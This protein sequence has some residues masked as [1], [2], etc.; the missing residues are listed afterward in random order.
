MDTERASR[1]ASQTQAQARTLVELRRSLHATIFADTPDLAHID[2]LRAS[3][4]EAEAAALAARV[5]LEM[6]IAQILTPEQRAQARELTA[7][8][9]GR[10]QRARDIRGLWPHATQP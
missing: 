3:I 7:R 8:A 1:T 9:P 2:Q 4:A 6:K 5:D 10:G